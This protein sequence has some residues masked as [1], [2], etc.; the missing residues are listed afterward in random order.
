VTGGRRPG[1]GRKPGFTHSAITRE[2]IRASQLINR[3]QAFVHGKL[4]RPM[5]SSQVKAAL[6]LLEKVI[7]DL[8][9]IE[10]SGRIAEEVHAITAEPLTDEEWVEIYGSR[11]RS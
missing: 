6:G 7:P 1:S 5:S 9:A 10:H 11:G 4:K 8:K 2:R 3:L